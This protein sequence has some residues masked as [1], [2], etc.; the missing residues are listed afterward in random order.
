MDVTQ[1]HIVPISPCSAAVSWETG[2]ERKF[3]FHMISGWLHVLHGNK[4]WI[5]LGSKW[6]ESIKTHPSL[7]LV[8]YVWHMRNP[9]YPGLSALEA[10]RRFDRRE[11]A[12]LRKIRICNRDS[13]HVQSACPREEGIFFNIFYECLI[14]ALAYLMV[15]KCGENIVF[16]LFIFIF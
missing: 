7:R 15:T 13:F 4:K 3:S 16:Q 2:G 14:S 10:L 8:V 11:I 1:K 5:I 9:W 12:A 6:T